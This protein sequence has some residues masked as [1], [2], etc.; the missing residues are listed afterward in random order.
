MQIFKTLGWGGTVAAVVIVAGL[1]VGMVL[2]GTARE[3]VI[4]VSGMALVHAVFEVV[5]RVL[6]AR[7]EKSN[8]QKSNR[9]APPPA[10]R[11]GDGAEDFYE[12]ACRHYGLK[13]FHG[14][15]GKAS[16]ARLRKR[17][18]ADLIR[19]HRRRQQDT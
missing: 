11:Q 17:Y 1:V 16:R 12:R 5:D 2:I 6:R 8:T 3:L 13:P 19:E 7:S 4:F 18:R 10:P 15:A 14:P 9:D